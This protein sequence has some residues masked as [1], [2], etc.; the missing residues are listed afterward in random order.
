MILQ[1]ENENFKQEIKKKSEEISSLNKE[2]DKIKQESSGS[3]FDFNSQINNDK[4]D[5]IQY[6]LMG[7]MFIV[8]VFGIFKVSKERTVRLKSKNNDSGIPPVNKL[9]VNIKEAKKGGSK[10]LF[11]KMILGF[12]VLTNY[13]KR[14]SKTMNAPEEETGIQTLNENPSSTHPTLPPNSKEMNDRNITKEMIYPPADNVTFKN[15]T[16]QD[17]T[18]PAASGFTSNVSGTSSDTTP[19]FVDP[20]ANSLTEEI[21]KW[22][23]SIHEEQI[24]NEGEDADPLALEL[25]QN[26]WLIGVFDGMGGAG[27]AQ[28][29]AKNQI[30]TKYSGAYLASRYARNACAGYFQTRGESVDV[31]KLKDHLLDQLHLAHSALET[32]ESKIKSRLIRTLPTTMALMEIRYDGQQ[33]IA[34]G[35]W[36]GDSRCYILDPLNGLQQISKDHLVNH[37]DA[38]ESITEDSTISNCICIDQDFYIDQKKISLNRACLLIVATDGAYGYVSSPWDFENLLLETLIHAK[39]FADWRGKVR[40]RIAQVAADDISIVVS[41]IGFDNFEKIKS[42][43]SQRYET[44]HKNYISESSVKSKEELWIDYKKSYYIGYQ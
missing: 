1:Q 23:F 41:Y 39:D 17:S 42:V 44:L 25:K 37:K 43:Y 10:S 32:K 36:V 33:F 16:V 40:D 2:L 4:L 29:W 13:M 24:M 30:D 9:T 38:L 18:N 5:Y 15:N 31:E 7:L 22:Y 19:Q 26:H 34:R 6:I 11:S 21:S 35:L 3:F 8:L 20:K 12:G 27:S 28:Y 14:K